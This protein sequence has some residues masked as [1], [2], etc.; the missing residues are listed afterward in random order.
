VIGSVVGIGLLQ[1]IKGIRQIRWNVLVGI[2]SGWITTPLLAAVMGFVLLFVVQNVFGQQVYQ[3]EVNPRTYPQRWNGPTWWTSPATD[4]VAQ[5]I[6][7][8][9]SKPIRAKPEQSGILNRT[10]ISLTMATPSFTWSNPEVSP[11]TAAA[12]RLSRTRLPWINDV[13]LKG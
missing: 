13:R 6:P 12:I 7:M 1:G 10:T 3:A 9:R 5:P 4:Q 2:A 11:I 8:A